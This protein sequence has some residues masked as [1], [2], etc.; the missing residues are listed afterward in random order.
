VLLLS[1]PYALK[2]ADAQTLG[3]LPASAFVQ[4]FPGGAAEK[5]G[6]TSVPGSLRAATSALS[7]GHIECH[8]HGWN[9]STPGDVYEGH[10][11]SEL[12]CVANGNN[13]HRRGRQPRYQ[14][15]DA[16]AEPRCEVGK[17]HRHRGGEF[18]EGGK[19]RE[20]STWVTPAIPSRPLGARD[21][22]SG[23]TKLPRRSLSP[24]PL[25][26]SVSGPRPLQLG[27]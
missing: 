22:R 3:G 5:A 24:T 16:V 20:L 2:A 21:W 9:G 18:L 4:A 14:Q 27:F 17:R 1:V 26:T 11:Y 8:H 19:H 7:S 12:D 13:G 15:Y 25:A 23:A 6:A 10:Q